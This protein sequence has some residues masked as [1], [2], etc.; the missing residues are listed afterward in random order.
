MASRFH[1]DGLMTS[2][3]M[4]YIYRSRWPDDEWPSDT[5]RCADYWSDGWNVLDGTIVSLSIVEMVL[6]PLS[7]MIFH[8]LL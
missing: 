2:G 5:C 7:H 8:D 1:P 4:T 6:T 3:L